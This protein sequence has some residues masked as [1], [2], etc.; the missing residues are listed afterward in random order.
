VSRPTFV[1][2]IG[3]QRVE[4][5]IAP[6]AE[7]LAVAL[8][9]TVD[10]GI[11]FCEAAGRE[12][13]AALSDL[14]VEVVASIA[15]MGIPIAIEVARSLGQDGYVIFHKT[16]K[17]HLTDAVAEPVRSI[18]TTGEQRLLLD[19]WRVEAVAGRRVALVDDVISTGGS[20]AAA[21][22]LLRRV[23]ATPVAVG[24][25]ATEGGS[26]RA[27][28]GEDAGLVRTLGTLP[29]FTPLAGGG[30]G[31]RDDGSGVA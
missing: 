26:W 28:L 24:A 2:T 23:D 11:G 21:L 27:A 10:L 15:T 6:L 9:I 7:D 19:R 29:L 5:P 31:T 8:L 12:L 25:L 1:A 3:S 14:E 17:I 4:L 13:A 30:F 22:R 18:T 20:V 16:P